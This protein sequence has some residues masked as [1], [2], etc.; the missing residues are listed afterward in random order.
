MPRFYIDTSV[1]NRLVCDDAG[2]EFASLEAARAVAVQALTEMAQE[3]MPDGDTRPVL[4][5]VRGED[6]STLLQASLMLRVTS[7]VAEAH[8]DDAPRIPSLSSSVRTPDATL[9][10]IL[11]PN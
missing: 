2:H 7:F 5:I 1:Q 10:P 3:T 11:S 8:R 4:A 6:G 9:R